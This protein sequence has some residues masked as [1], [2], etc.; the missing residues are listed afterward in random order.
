MV[1]WLF[2][3][4]PWSCLWFVIVVFPGHTCLL[5]LESTRSII[6]VNED[7]QI[8]NYIEPNVIACSDALVDVGVDTIN[9]YCG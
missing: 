8:V 1:E 4:V 3:A 2:I 5:Y 9:N 7:I 6:I